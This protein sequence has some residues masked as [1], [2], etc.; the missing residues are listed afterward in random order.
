MT[1]DPY[2]LCADVTCPHC[3]VKGRLVAEQETR[4]F[5]DADDEFEMLTCVECGGLHESH[6]SSGDEH[7]KAMRIQF[8]RLIEGRPYVAP[9]PEQS[10][11]P[12]AVESAS[13][14]IAGLEPWLPTSPS[15]R[16]LI[17]RIKQYGGEPPNAVVVGGGFARIVADPNVPPGSFVIVTDIKDDE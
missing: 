10:K 7:L 11:A 8:G 1:H 5:E 6:G 3:G 14:F 15:I 17:E 16:D 12:P 9:E 2:K 13:S 4:Y